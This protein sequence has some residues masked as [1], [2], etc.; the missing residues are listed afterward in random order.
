LNISDKIK[1]KRKVSQ[2]VMSTPYV[3]LEDGAYTLT[4]MIKSSSGFITLEMY[5]ESDKKRL[6]YS[7]AGENASWTTIKIE[8][9]KVK[10][11]K[12]EI[13]FEAEGTANA[14]C[15]VDDVSLVRTR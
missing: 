1:F 9:V 15:Y 5:A 8:R 11:G 10:N 7:I 4:A 14:F 13:G 3:K 12:M 2:T 6:T